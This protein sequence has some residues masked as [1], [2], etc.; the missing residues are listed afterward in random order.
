MLEIVSLPEKN[1][2]KFTFS[3][4]LSVAQSA[5]LQQELLKAGETAP[6]IILHVHR[7]DNMD[8]SFL[9]LLFSWGREMKKSGKNLIF[10]FR[11]GE[12]FQRI[13]EQSGFA[14]A[15]ARL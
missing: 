11:L 7:V 6:Q 12:E 1:S 9:Q 3:G 4:D 13:Y 5:E 2:T 8:L 10:D 15:F 14:Q